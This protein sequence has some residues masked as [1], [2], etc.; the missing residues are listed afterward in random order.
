MRAISWIWLLTFGSSVLAVEALAGSASVRDASGIRYDYLTRKGAD[1]T[2]GVLE[3]RD[4]TTQELIFRNT[5]LPP[6]G[7]VTGNLQ[8]ATRIAITVPG[9]RPRKRELIVLCGSDGE[10][11]Q[12]LFILETGQLLGRLDFGSSPPNLDWDAKRR[13]F[14]SQ[15]YARVPDEAGALRNL[16]LV[17]ELAPDSVLRDGFRPIFNSGSAPI[18]RSYYESQKTG[19]AS[20]S[21]SAYGSMLAALVATSDAPYV[22]KELNVPPLNSLSAADVQRRVNLNERYGLPS[23]NLS[24]CQ[25]G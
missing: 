17:Y 23:F 9:I 8:Q 19:P 24:T 5:R 15:V 20:A 1:G 13:T 12:T 16:L 10:H 21:E 3:A 14:L 7:C 18:Y 6:P 11:H 22:C 2:A 4:I 25:K